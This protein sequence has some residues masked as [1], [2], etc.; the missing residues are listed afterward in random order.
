MT[1]RFDQSLPELVRIIANNVSDD[2]FAGSVFLRD[3]TGYLSVVLDAILLEEVLAQLTEQV[4][5]GIGAYARED[6]AVRDLSGPG[7][8]R[9]LDAPDVANV[10]VGGLTVRFVDRRMVGADWLL[11][12]AVAQ[13]ATRIAFASIKGGVGR[14]TALAVAA[15]HLSRRGLRVLAIDLDLE[16]PGIGSMLLSEAGLPTYGSL[17]YLVENGISQIDDEFLAN[18]IGKSS[19]GGGGGQVTVVPAFGRATLECPAGGLAKIARAYL[20]DVTPNGTISLTAQVQEMVKRLEEAGSYD[21]TL[22]DARAGLHETTAAVL[23][24][25]SAETLLFGIDEPQTFYG[26]RL[27]MAHLAERNPPGLNAWRDR[28]QFVHAKAPIR[29]TEQF[30][31]AIRFR[32]LLD[33][34]NPPAAE[35]ADVA[36]LTA[37]DFDVEWSDDSPDTDIIFS[38]DVPVIPILDD[39]RYR[40]FD[41][42][43]QPDLL[44]T[45]SFSAT[46][47]S[48]LEWVER[49]VIGS[50][51]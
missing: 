47:G 38:D 27:L 23:L 33:V 22:I 4:K 6:S 30:D 11:A 15:V 45:E 46:F 24:G 31:A 9:L 16:A 50:E 37:E 28:L 29:P 41:P 26:Y 17:D 35:T 39:P 43:R 34:F 7:A 10:L 20:E 14:S 40:G 51:G 5:A 19:L 44:T 42:A 8:A 2:V 32:D 49:V 3:A 1:I 12:P 48:L 18:V 13:N 36:G 21:V 25:L